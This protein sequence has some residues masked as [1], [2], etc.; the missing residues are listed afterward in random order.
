MPLKVAM[1]WSV[2]AESIL[3]LK[4]TGSEKVVG[5]RRAKQFKTSICHKIEGAVYQCLYTRPVVLP[6]LFCRSAGT[7]QS[8]Q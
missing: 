8:Q 4:L 3:P 5:P 6:D 1:R 2:E 7:A